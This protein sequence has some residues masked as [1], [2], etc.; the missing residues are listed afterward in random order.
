MNFTKR[1]KDKKCEKKE[2]SML[3][4]EKKRKFQQT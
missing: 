2:R 3:R 1:H 4:D